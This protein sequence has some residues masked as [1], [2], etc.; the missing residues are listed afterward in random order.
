MNKQRTIA[1]TDLIEIKYTGGPV[2]AAEFAKKFKR[3]IHAL[4]GNPAN[5]SPNCS[6][7]IKVNGASDP[8]QV[9]ECVDRELDRQLSA[10][11]V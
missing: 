8:Q 11:N 2:Q 10:T 6:V 7:T 4:M 5:D 9:A 1:K 3:E